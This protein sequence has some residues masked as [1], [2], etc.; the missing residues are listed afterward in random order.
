MR[1]QRTRGAASVR[2]VVLAVAVLT[3]SA[4]ATVTYNKASSELIESASD[5]LYAL[6]ELRRDELADYYESV[7]DGTLFWARNPFLRPALPAFIEAWNELGGDRQA[8]LQR[9]YIEENP[10]PVGQKGRLEDAGDGSSY[11]AT[12]AQYHAFLKRF[13]SQWGFY[14]VFL[15][16][17][18]GNLV[19]SGFK[20]SDFATNFVTGPWRDTDLGRAF[21][22]ARDSARRGHFVMFDF[23]PYPPSHDAPASFTASPVVDDDGELV[24]VLAFQV[25]IE[26]IDEIMQVVQGMG[27]TGETYAVGDD[28]LMR[29]DSRFSE[30]ST[31]LK[32][33]VDTE[34]ARLA[35]AGES[36]VRITDDFRGVSVLSAYGPLELDGV[37]AWAVLAEVD[38]AE[39]LAPVARLRTWLVLAGVI[40]VGV[41]VLIGASAG[42]LGSRS[43]AG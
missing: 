26:R 32:T 18:A 19:Y 21:R 37:T 38:E 27:E 12:H 42:L 11:S 34:T 4:V 30:E 9:L 17:P 24:G 23:A 31:I 8:T 33:T 15:F 6:M 20:E 29:S 41:M 39:I 1:S 16:D 13:I 28:L 5:N 36:G 14:D 25:S 22:A 43:R 35:L 3:A 40:L 10:H 7:R 2:T